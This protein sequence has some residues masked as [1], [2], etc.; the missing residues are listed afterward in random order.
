MI[1]DYLLP[2]FQTELILPAYFIFSFFYCKEGSV[3]MEQ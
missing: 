1:S 2:M 3:T